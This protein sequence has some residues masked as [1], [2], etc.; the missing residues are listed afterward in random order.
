M[1]CVKFR[2]AP[3]WFFEFL[4]KYRVILASLGKRCRKILL[5]AEYLMMRI[6]ARG[7]HASIPSSSCVAEKIPSRF[8]G[9]KR[10]FGEQSTADDRVI[11]SYM[12]RC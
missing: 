4:D 7:Y 10:K 2:T 6:N 12:V 5:K 9:D 11:E 1:D 8:T 3:M